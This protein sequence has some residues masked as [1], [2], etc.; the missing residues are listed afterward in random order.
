ML[1]LLNK[2]LEARD[3]Y[4]ADKTDENLEEFRRRRDEFNIEGERAPNKGDAAAI[5]KRF[6]DGTSCYTAFVEH[7]EVDASNN[8]AERIIRKVVMLRNITQGTRSP[9][10]RIS[11][12]RFLS[13]K[14]TCELQGRFF[15]DFF[16]E[17]YEAHLK[18]EPTPSILPID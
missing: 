4:N 17:S 15:R 14:A 5:A 9:A 13:V 2:L 16:K 1:G 8:R 11:M 18:G 3:T 10:G 6:H 12:E 7:P